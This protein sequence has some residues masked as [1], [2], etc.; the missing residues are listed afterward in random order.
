[1]F[2]DVRPVLFLVGILIS[3]IGVMMFPVALFS[4]VAGNEDWIIFV[5]CG[6][7]NIVTGGV[8]TLA[9]WTNSR[10]GLTNRQALLFSSL[11]WVAVCLS[12]ATPFLWYSGDMSLV[13]SVF[14]AVS[15]FTTTGSTIYSNLQ[16]QLPS[17]L[18]W[19]SM[20]CWIGGF[21]VII[22]AIAFLPHLNM[23]GMQLFRRESGD[24]I[25]D[26]VLPRAVELSKVV[27]FLYIGASILCAVF[28]R[29]MGMN[30][31]DA[32]NHAMTTVSTAG[33]STN[34]NSIG[35]FQNPAI[36]WVAIVFMIIGA[37][38]FLMLF[39]VVRGRPVYLVRDPQVRTFFVV[40][41]ILSIIM[42]ILQK[43]NGSSIAILD[44]FRL[45]IFNIV[46][47]VTGTGYASTDYSS[48]GHAAVTFFFFATFIGGCAG[49]TSCGVKIFR[50]QVLGAVVKIEAQRIYQPHQVLH[51]IYNGYK[52][53]DP[54]IE[55]VMVFMFVFFVAF[56]VTSICLALTGV[57]AIT[58][59]SGAV[60][61]ISN[62]GPGLG[63]VIGPS[64]NFG[65]LSDT[66]KWILIVAMLLGR[67]E[68]LIVL[69]IFRARFWYD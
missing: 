42:V 7:L 43:N 37:I 25:S 45:A 28:Y 9:T 60:T 16:H 8:F 12:G 20:L 66:A 33:F 19:R 59:L 1:M 3:F 2:L 17:I 11:S 41:L 29:A 48:W 68:F 58:A 56:A 5:I 31:F 27:F 13:D 24:Q 38:P 64:G 67:M 51:P 14:E 47:I 69:I 21:G 6:V 26:K 23:G 34:D 54:I 36:E 39:Q 32:I 65:S 18:L 30:V 62:V 57:D 50:W 53:D 10:A 49:S 61:A 40:V 35:G 52:L 46:S 44:A 15:G 22:F 63:S 55:S 4:L